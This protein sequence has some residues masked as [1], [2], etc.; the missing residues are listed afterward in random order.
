MSRVR[1][2]TVVLLACVPNATLAAAQ[3]PSSSPAA[4]FAILADTDL[5]GGDIRLPWKD[6][7]LRGLSLAQCQAICT[8]EPACRAFTYNPKGRMCFIKGDGFSEKRFAGAASGKRLTVTGAS[9]QA[10]AST[11]RAEAPQIRDHG[12]AQ[13]A[14]LADTDLT[15]GDIR[16]PSDDPSLSGVSHVSHCQVMC[17]SE[18]ACR[19]FTYNSK[20]RMCFIKGHGF[21]EKRLVGAVSGKRLDD[22]SKSATAAEPD[23]PKSRAEF[24][25][26]VLEK[27]NPTSLATDYAGAWHNFYRYVVPAR[28]LN[29]GLYEQ[30]LLQLTEDQSSCWTQRERYARLACEA[31]AAA[32]VASSLTLFEESLLFRK[33]AVMFAERAAASDPAPLIDTLLGLTSNEWT[34]GSLAEAQTTVNRLSVMLDTQPKSFS[35]EQRARLA[36]LEARLADA[37]LD[38]SKALSAWSQAIR[39]AAAKEPPLSVFDAIDHYTT[40]LEQPTTNPGL[41]DPGELVALHLRGRFCPNCG[42]PIA[43]PA[44]RWLKFNLNTDGCRASML[45]LLAAPLGII[46]KAQLELCARHDLEAKPDMVAAIRRLLPPR[47]DDITTAH[48]LALSHFLEEGP[49]AFNPFKKD[50]PAFRIL[51]EPDPRRQTDMMKNALKEVAGSAY[52]QFGADLALP[53]DFEQA[54]WNF[55]KAGLHNSARATLEFLIDWHA[56]RQTE[57]EVKK[58]MAK[59]IVN[60]KAV[61]QAR[62]FVTALSRLAA[63]QLAAGDRAAAAKSLTDAS[64]IA[65]AKLRQE[66]QQGGERTI[67]T[68]RDLATP[69]R[70]I[71]QTQHE[72]IAPNGFADNPK[73]ADALFRA[74]QAALT[75][76]TALTLEVALQRRIL[77]TP[78]LAELK[79]EHTR[80]AVEVARMAEIEKR[81]AAFNYDEILTKAREDVAQ[82]RDQIA[83]ELGK[84]PLPPAKEI[85]DIEPVAHED[86]RKHL[87]ENEA[88]VLLQVTPQSLNGVL[89][90]R[91]GKTLLWRST[92]RSSDLE[93]LVRSLRAGADMAADKIPTFPIADAARLYDVVF[94]P[95]ATRLPSYGKLILLGDG[96]LQ[97]LP[98]GILLAAHPA[99]PPKAAE[100]FRAAKLP[101]LIRTHAVALVPSVRSFVTQRTA[102]L[103]SQ[104][105]RPF[106]GVGNPQLAAAG[107]GQRSVDVTAVFAGS[108]GLADIDLLRRLVSLPETEMELRDIAAVLKARADDIIVGA[109]ANEAAVKTLPLDQYRIIAF[110]TH[111]ALAGEVAGTSEPGLVLTPPPKATPEDDG[112]L[113]LSEIAGLKLDADLV[114]LSACNTGTSDGRPRAES[115]SGLARGFFN[116]GARSLLVTHWTIPSD[117]AVKTTTGLVAARV[118][119][120]RMDWADALREAT[121]AIIDREGPPE[122]AH[123]TFWGAFVAIGVLPAQ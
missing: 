112:F 23:A 106:L 95:I 33:D 11:A 8:A 104:A 72:L 21:S 10:P 108:Q 32:E 58:G 35:Y 59:T 117:S 121:L 9:P 60:A 88:L 14:I 111:G 45:T 79:R 6:P 4:Q 36:V 83:A 1:I 42:H 67:L 110:A 18:P 71:S 120:E 84:L 123:P 28:F 41:P 15:G 107:T 69:L 5:S 76:E 29:R 78:G 119:D 47:A 61:R 70:L 89:L 51:R 25:K 98:Y 43:E 87:A 49:W 102:A 37:H 94:G 90:D 99:Q 73:G 40:D 66:W 38:D 97:S 92:I 100:E 85:A 56:Q 19:A 48:M 63:L 22:P 2:S 77:N 50:Y 105:P 12:A 46:S 74:M 103:A 93:A 116:A 68:L 65:H 122:W 44:R 3:S 114:I 55:E 24:E 20:A 118:R 34:H 26:L 52:E 30:A 57:E 53:T 27:A 17:A 31:N 64:A 13:F 82:R 96:P 101:W 115:L 54:A 62:V 91:D 80:A 16:L 86:A 39:A 109:K 7:A 113:S 81:Y 75:G